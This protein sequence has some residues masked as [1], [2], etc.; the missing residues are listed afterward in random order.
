M[1][2]IIN[3]F[4]IGIRYWICE[5]PEGMY[6]GLQEI[7]TKHKVEWEQL[8]FDLDVLTHYGYSHWSDLSASPEHTGFLLDAQNRIE[9][10]H[11]TK[12]IARFRANE[13]TN[14]TTLFPLYNSKQ[15]TWEPER[16]A[17]RNTFLL[18]QYEKGLIGKYKVDQPRIHINDLEFQWKEVNGLRILAKIKYQHHFLKRS[19]DDA[20]C[21]SSQVMQLH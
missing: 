6:E 14:E 10:K 17:K 3:L 18:L 16:H 21:I 4:G 9:I 1:T 19:A 7:R 15:V 2:C 11:G 5:V 20:L 12:F 8:L 13:L